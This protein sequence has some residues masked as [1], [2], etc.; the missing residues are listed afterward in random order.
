MLNAAL[1]LDLLHVKKNMLL[2]VGAKSAHGI[3]L[4]QRTL[5]TPSV[6]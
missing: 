4:Y 5:R 6:E 2:K 1:F 3:Y